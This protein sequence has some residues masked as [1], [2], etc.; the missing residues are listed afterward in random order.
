MRLGIPKIK[1]IVFSFQNFAVELHNRD[2]EVGL[3][4]DVCFKFS[5][6]KLVFF[7]FTIE[8]EL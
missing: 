1:T 5:I 7:Y 3:I 2:F 4:Y 8:Q 6:L